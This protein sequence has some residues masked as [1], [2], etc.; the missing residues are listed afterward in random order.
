[1]GRI[2]L[3][4]YIY[5]YTQLLPMRPSLYS[6]NCHIQPESQIR[7]A[8]H[9]HVLVTE[10]RRTFP[11]PTVVQSVKVNLRIQSHLLLILLRP[12]RLRVRSSNS[13]LSVYILRYA[14]RIDIQST[15][16]QNYISNQQNISGSFNWPQRYIYRLFSR[17]FLTSF[18]LFIFCDLQP[19]HQPNNFI[20]SL[21]SFVW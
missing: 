7:G 11:N 6:A 14:T 15:D 9:L 3:S 4:K 17:C 20:S 10:N 5:I 21:L 18:P 13:D 19:Y 2:F 12:L 8:A 1:M 16:L